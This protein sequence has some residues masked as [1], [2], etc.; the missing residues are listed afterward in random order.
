MTRD[1]RGMQPPNLA[2][3]FM[4]PIST[5]GLNPFVFPHCWKASDLAAIDR[6]S[7]SP[8][9]GLV[10]SWWNRR[11]KGAVTVNPEK[12]QENEQTLWQWL[13]VFFRH[14]LAPYPGRWSLVARMV[15][16]A[17]LS[18]IVIITFRIPYGAIGV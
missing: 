17:T 16:A 2:Q 11:G 13:S 7:T 12:G 3:R 5:S 15:I 6:R 18:M 8:P 4:R 9:D 1:G 10:V 14:E